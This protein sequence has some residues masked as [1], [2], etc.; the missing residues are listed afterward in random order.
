VNNDFN[1]P[2]EVELIPSGL[3]DGMDLELESAYFL[4]NPDEERIL[5]GR[6]TVDVNKI[7][8]APKARRQCDYHFNLH[9]LYRTEDALLPFGGFSVDVNP[10]AESKLAFR[11]TRRGEQD[12][13]V[14]TG[15]LSGPFNSNQ[16]VD[17]AVMVKG[18]AFGGTAVTNGQGRFEIPVKVPASGPARLMLYYFG[19]DMA[20]SSAGPADIKIP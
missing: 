19:P 17:A 4:L 14:I 13:V 20:S 5:R 16:K 6:L 1:W 18:K 15:L 2:I 11:E 10:N 7:P 9:A 12:Q 8:P 3:A